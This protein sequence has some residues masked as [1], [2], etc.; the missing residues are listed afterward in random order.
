MA[1][2][3]GIDG[4]SFE[5]VKGNKTGERGVFFTVQ[6]LRLLASN[7]RG[8]R[9]KIPCVVQ[10]SQENIFLVEEEKISGSYKD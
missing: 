3:I 10:H 7:A 5:K 2:E 9:T 4:G 6:W 1:K 8:Q